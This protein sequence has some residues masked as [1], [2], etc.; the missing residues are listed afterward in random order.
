MRSCSTFAAGLLLTGGFQ[1][2]QR[3]SARPLSPA[4]S[5]LSERSSPPSTR[6][7]HPLCPQ[8]ELLTDPLLVGPLPCTSA[9]IRQGTPLESA[10]P[11]ARGSEAHACRGSWRRTGRRT[12]AEIRARC[13]PV[14]VT[15]SVES[16]LMPPQTEARPGPK[17]GLRKRRRRRSCPTTA[18]AVCAI[19]PLPSRPISPPAVM[20][21]AT[22]ACLRSNHARATHSK[23][24]KLLAGCCRQRAL[25]LPPLQRACQKEDAREAVL[26]VTIYR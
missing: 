20:W 23:P 6:S 8:S 19:G 11:R 12:G 26:R 22:G 1:T 17:L 18:A 13:V 4:S 24:A 5:A 9:R 21:L 15:L 25:R 10:H 7:A 16:L 2:W 14:S 3:C